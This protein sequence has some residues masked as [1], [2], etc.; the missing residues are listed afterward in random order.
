MKVYK[1]KARP[2]GRAFLGL[3]DEWIEYV[4]I[5]I[6]YDYSGYDV[7]GISEFDD[8][9][10]VGEAPCGLFVYIYPAIYYFGRIGKFLW[11]TPLGDG[12]P[13]A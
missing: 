9:L 4:E 13:G 2:I 10:I 12:N 7:V 1:R 5:A 3:I 6:F 11:Y 8:V